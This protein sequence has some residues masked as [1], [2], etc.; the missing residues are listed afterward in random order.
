MTA[1]LLGIAGGALQALPIL[2]AA[3]LLRLAARRRARAHAR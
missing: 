3:A 1:T 2:A